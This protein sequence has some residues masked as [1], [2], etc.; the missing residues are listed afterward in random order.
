MAM[1]TILDSAHVQ[2]RIRLA[3]IDAPE[4]RQAFGNVSKQHLATLVYRLPVRVEWTKRDRYG[5]IIGKVYQHG[6]DVCLEQVKAGLAWHYKRYEKEQTPADRESYA[7]AESAAR[8]QKLG[9]W[10]DASPI[11]P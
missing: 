2:H 11:E 7:A 4:K 8:V 1:I 10:A 6:T 5:R 3:G 9:L